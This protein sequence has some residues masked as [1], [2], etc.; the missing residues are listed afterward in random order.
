[1]LLLLLVVMMLTLELWR[2]KLHRVKNFCLLQLYKTP[3]WINGLLLVQYFLQ[4]RDFSD[5]C[6]QKRDFIEN[7]SERPKIRAKGREF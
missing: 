3:K 1:M 6:K 5:S 2:S 4:R 7:F